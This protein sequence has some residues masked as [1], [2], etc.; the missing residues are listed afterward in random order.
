MNDDADLLQ[1]YTQGGSEQAFNQLVTR[2]LDLVYSAAVRQVGGDAHLGQDVSQAVFATLAK[3][4]RWMPAGVVLGGWL[5]RCACLEAAQAVRTE[6]RR[7]AREQVAAEMNSLNDNDEPDWEHLAPFLDEAMGRLRRRD[8][9]AV[10]LRYF[11]KR[12]LRAVG[13][14]L[15]I[16]E[17]AARMRIARTLERLRA[18]FTRRGL[19]LSGAT[20]A[21][22][23]AGHAVAAA[24]AGLVVHITGAALA[25]AAVGGGSFISSL[26]IMAMTKLKLSIASAVVVVGLGASLGFEYHS[27]SKLRQENA[28]LREQTKQVEGLRAENERMAGL[29]RDASELE[30]LRAE[31][32]DLLRLRAE[33]TSLRQRQGDMAR[34][35][36]ENQQLSAMRAN[37]TQGSTEVV[38]TRDRDVIEKNACIVNLKMIDAAREQWA[39]ENKQRTGAQP[40]FNAVNSYL[41]NSQAPICPA[42]GTYSY[43]TIGEPPTCSMG[44]TLGH[45]L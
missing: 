32:L 23:L 6:R 1:R 8:R 21:S 28:A 2:Y 18:C 14:A 29:K 45:T 17:D 30:R 44:P 3:K 34:L 38:V 36:S 27:A 22:L 10:V 37:Q 43:N 11:E 42:N 25:A 13:L 16:S 33:V 35:Q 7:R 12:D 19:T 39:L 20:L 40:D 41:R 5:Y 31:H 26:Q 4:A 15:G 9:E 24:P